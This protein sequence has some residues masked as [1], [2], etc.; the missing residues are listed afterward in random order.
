MIRYKLEFAQHESKLVAD[1][2]DNLL[3]FSLKF[4]SNKIVWNDL[5][6]EH[7]HIHS[8]LIAWVNSL[9]I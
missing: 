9:P 5:M 7:F 2:V 6:T 1:D 3:F 8:G 4:D